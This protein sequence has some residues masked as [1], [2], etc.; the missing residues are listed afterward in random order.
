MKRLAWS[1]HI[2]KRE[3]SNADVWSGRGIILIFTDHTTKHVRVVTS[4][5][6]RM[7]VMKVSS[8][9]NHRIMDEEMI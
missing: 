2:T 7:L 1:D 5:S 4:K 9:V 8:R 6:L 3:Y